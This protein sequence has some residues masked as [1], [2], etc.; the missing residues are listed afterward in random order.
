[1]VHGT[2]LRLLQLSSPTL[3]IGSYAYSQGVESAVHA[4]VIGNES[5]AYEWLKSVLLNGMAYGDLALLNHYYHAWCNLDT[6][7]LQRLNELSSAI[8]ETHEL[9]Q[10][11][12]HLAKALLRLANSFEIDFAAMNMANLSYPFVYARIAQ[13]WQATVQEAMLAFCWSWLE[14]QIAALVK[15]VPLGQTQG[16]LLM[17]KMDDVILGAVETAQKLEEDD[18]GNSLMMLAILSSQHE[19]Q[20]SRL[21]RS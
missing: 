7:R 5:T 10:E 18:I 15:L 1:M 21:F 14:N 4:G 3:P 16:Q 19:I 17:Y 9:W 8:R 20:Y 6:E 12:Q 13:Q 2:L 11:D